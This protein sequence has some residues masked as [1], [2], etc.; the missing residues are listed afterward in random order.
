MGIPGLSMRD[1]GYPVVGR[2]APCEDVGIE[3]VVG[4]GDRWSFLLS[5]LLRQRKDGLEEVCSR[6]GAFCLERRGSWI[7]WIE[8][9]CPSSVGLEPQSHQCDG[10]ETQQAHL[11]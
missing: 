4:L 9:I 3:H 8:D 11:K 10:R 7:E 2:R 6:V 5:P 1:R